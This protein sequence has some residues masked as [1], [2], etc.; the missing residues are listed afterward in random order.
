MDQAPRRLGRLDRASWQPREKVGSFIIAWAAAVEAAASAT[1]IPDLFGR[2]E[3]C[4]QLKRL[5]SSIEPTMYRAAILSDIEL[6]QLR[7]IENVVRAGRVRRI[8]TDRI[9]LDG[10][11]VPTS[12]N[13]LYV[14]CTADGLPK[15]SPRPIFE[16]DRVTIQ[17]MRET[18]PTFNAALIG[19]LEATRD[20]VDEQNAL[21]PPNTV[22]ELGDGLDPHA[23]R[24]NGRP[25]QVGSDT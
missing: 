2:L 10:G 4:G 20:D 7:S 24:R 25:A 17:Q 3:E 9:V 23:T 8:Q 6:E 16:P 5:D 12:G 11:E 22:S 13:R 21:A 19:Y 18:S 14:D 15:L 1:S